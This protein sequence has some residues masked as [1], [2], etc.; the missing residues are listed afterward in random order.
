[1]I[2][3]A[4]LQSEVQNKVYYMMNLDDPSISS[5]GWSLPGEAEK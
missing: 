2:S 1:M 3:V 4:R 5:L